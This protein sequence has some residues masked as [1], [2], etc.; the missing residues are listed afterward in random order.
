VVQLGENGG[1][2]IDFL[3]I[4]RQMIGTGGEPL[5]TPEDMQK[6]RERM[7]EIQERIRERE[8]EIEDVVSAEQSV[9]DEEPQKPRAAEEE[10]AER[11]E[12]IRQSVTD[13]AVKERV[14]RLQSANGEADSAANAEPEK[15][16]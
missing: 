8:Q 14:E 12:E 16:T 10:N 2:T 11:L 7:E 13:E 1:Q 5:F 15:E 4:A 6:I 3:S 9:T